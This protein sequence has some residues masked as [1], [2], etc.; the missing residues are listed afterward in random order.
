ML[1]SQKLREETK[2]SAGMIF[3]KEVHSIDKGIFGCENRNEKERNY[4]LA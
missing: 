4:E 3:I 1:C 2:I